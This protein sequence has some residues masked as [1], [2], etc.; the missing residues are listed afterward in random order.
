MRGIDA[1]HADFFA[2]ERELLKRAGQ[3]C[4][5]GVAV[6][7]GE[8]LRRRERAADHVAFELGHVDPVRREAAE[9]LVK[10]GRN[11]ADAEHEGRDHG[12]AAA[13]LRPLRYARQNDEAGGVVRV[14]LDVFR[15]DGEIVDS[16]GKTRR[17]RGPCRIAPG[18]NFARRTGRVGGHDRC[19]PMVD[20]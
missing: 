9:R 16:G 3:S 8:E 17:E 10:S 1:E 19:Q 4:A 5:V 18:G 13:D 20:V 11:V 2:V 15:Q 7:I 14:V 12:I 6:D